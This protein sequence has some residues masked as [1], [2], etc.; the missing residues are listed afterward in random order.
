[1]TNRN[2]LKNPQLWQSV[3]EAAASVRSV[4]QWMRGSPL[5]E[6]AES[7]SE[8]NVRCNGDDSAKDPKQDPPF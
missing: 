7:P 5:N 4:P 1:M 2:Q 6:R 8:D 3:S